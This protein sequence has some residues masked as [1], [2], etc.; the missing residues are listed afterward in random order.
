MTCEMM[1]SCAVAIFDNRDAQ[2]QQALPTAS[3]EPP[4]PR[5]MPAD[6]HLAR[7]NADM[8]REGFNRMTCLTDSTMAEAERTQRS[9]S[10]SCAPGQPK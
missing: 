8:C 3:S 2:V 10:S 5:P 7:R 4:K 1:I 9:A 6:D